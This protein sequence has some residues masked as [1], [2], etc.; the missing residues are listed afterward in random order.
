MKEYKVHHLNPKFVMSTK[1]DID[2]AQKEI[3][4]LAEEGWELVT[5]VSP[6]NL[7]G[8]MVGYFQREK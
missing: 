3:D 5:V 7:I 8:S 1:Q 4:K 2:Q 6:N